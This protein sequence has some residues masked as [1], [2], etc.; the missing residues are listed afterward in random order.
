MKRVALIAAALVFVIVG[1]RADEGDR[2]LCTLD[3][4]Q[5]QQSIDAYANIHPVFVDRRCINCH[6]GVN[7]LVAKG[8]HLGGVIPKEESQQCAGC[9]NRARAPWQLAKSVFVGKSPSDLCE[10][11]QRTM[12][13]EEFLQ[14]ASDDALGFIAV[15]FAGTRGLNGAG[16][17]EYEEVTG[18]VFRP[19]PVKAST[20]DVFEKNAHAWVAALGSFQKPP[21][22][23]CRPLRYQLVMKH[24]VNWDERI[25]KTHHDA[26]AVDAE[27]VF[28]LVV[29]NGLFAAEATVPRTLTQN[30]G[31]PGAACKSTAEWTETWDVNGEFVRDGA[32]AR[33]TLT[34]ERA[35]PLSGFITCVTPKRTVTVPVPPGTTGSQGGTV[36]FE[37]PARIDEPKSI[38]F[39]LPGPSGRSKS[40][41]V[42]VFRE[43]QADGSPQPAK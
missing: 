14:H 4:H 6:G 15:A 22:C 9:H 11:F 39:Q 7:P 26:K 1:A 43:S 35:T 31:A 24:S 10:C 40:A 21:G 28:D 16:E 25:A 30:V 18:K 29:S 5:Q 17:A 13:T 36:E 3:R 12:T 33:I 19:E 34:T 42:A 27:V 8:G 41:M 38:E 23:G 20:F 37:M 32:A 2:R